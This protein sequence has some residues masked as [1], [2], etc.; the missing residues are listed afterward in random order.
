MRHRFRNISK[1]DD[2]AAVFR[3]ESLTG[4]RTLVSMHKDRMLLQGFERIG[5][6]NDPS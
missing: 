1:G 6:Q 3:G 4:Y 2:E 5:N